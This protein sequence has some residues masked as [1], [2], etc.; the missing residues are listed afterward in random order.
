MLDKAKS[1]T[2]KLIT[3]SYSLPAQKIDTMNIGP[4]EL[5]KL[6]YARDNWNITLGSKNIIESDNDWTRSLTIEDTVLS[7]D[8]LKKIYSDMDVVENIDKNRKE[9]D[10]C[11]RR[12]IQAV[13]DQQ[14]SQATQIADGN[15]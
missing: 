8:E 11:S 15:R 14:T 1:E 6:F 12:N 7:E 10:G 9:D 2:E 5:E 13:R 3:I 4:E